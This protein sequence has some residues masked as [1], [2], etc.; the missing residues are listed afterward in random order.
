MRIEQDRNV[1]HLEVAVCV[2]HNGE[3]DYED[4]RTIACFDEDSDDEANALFDET[5]VEGDVYCVLILWYDPEYP[6]L[7]P[8]RQKDETGEV[9]C[10]D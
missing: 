3:Q 5:K 10:P 9:E 7:H 1:R 4:M 8:I 6:E 2:L